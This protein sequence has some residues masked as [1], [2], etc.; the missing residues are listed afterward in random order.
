MADIQDPRV[1]RDAWQDKLY[2]LNVLQ[3]E[4]QSNARP[5]FG[6]IQNMALQMGAAGQ[7]F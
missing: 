6:Q 1:E 3:L 2:G 4:R 7:P 5:A